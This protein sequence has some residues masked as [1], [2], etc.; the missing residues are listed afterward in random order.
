MMPNSKVLLDHLGLAP[1]ERYALGGLASS[2]ERRRQIFTCYLA[3][4]EKVAEDLLSTVASAEPGIN[5]HTH[6]H[7]RRV[8][9]HIEELIQ[10]SYPKPNPILQG[11]PE[12]REISWADV[13]ILLSALVWH[14]IGNM[15]GRQGHAARVQEVLGDVGN[16]LY[17]EHLRRLITQVAKAH[18]STCSNGRIRER[19]HS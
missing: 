11:F 16:H 17:D 1:L 7:L 14:D 10:W 12:D 19:N 4:R 3:M 9:E 2:V 5:D 13:V 8:L 15:Y 6:R 18:S